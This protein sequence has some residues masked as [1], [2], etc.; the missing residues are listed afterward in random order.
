MHRLG[1]VALLG[2]A[3]TAGA[4]PAAVQQVGTVPVPNLAA[5]W[6]FDEMSGTSA[7]DVSGNGN[8][9]M[10]QGTVVI[11]SSV[12][13]FPGTGR[14]LQFSQAG[15]TFVQVPSSASLQLSG[16]FTL[17]AWINVTD[18]A[19]QHG[20]LEK[21][22]DPA[23]GYFMRLNASEHLGLSVFP[24]AGGAQGISTTPRVV[25][26]GQW[27]HVASVYDAGAMRLYVN[28]VADATTGAGLPAPGVE[29]NM[30]RIGRD[31]GGNGLQG[32][33]DEPRIYN[34]GLS[35]GEIGILRVGQAPPTG[36]VATPGAGQVTLNWT[37]PAAVAG[38]T[39][40]Y[41]IKRSTT[42]GG[43]YTVV[44]TGVNTTSYTDTGLG[45]GVAYFYV[46]SAVS[47]LESV[48]SSEATTV[49]LNPTPRTKDHEEGLFG[50][51]CSCGASA[52]APGPWAAALALLGA[53]LLRRRFR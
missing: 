2:L 50:D 51:Q 37:A 33:I 48:N 3:A 31:Y 8:N 46:V 43:P 20:I 15:G 42:A 18:A 27:I 10:H 11:S 41:A 9:G 1:W 6:P 25:P 19:N 13:P 39:V 30:L 21:W 12:P 36:L 28:G 14:S 7:A 44:T 52:L 17:A 40:V 24:G 4:A 5:Y 22:T 16:S 23:G 32:N 47:V 35:A 26:L 38:S 45:L 49:T 53:V 29:G 34:R